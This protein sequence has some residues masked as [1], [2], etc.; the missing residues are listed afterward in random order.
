MTRQNW[1]ILGTGLVLAVMVTLVSGCGPKLYN[2]GTYKGISQ[3]DDHGYAVAEVTVKGD[4]ITAVKLTEFTQ[5]GVEKDFNTYP[6]AK[7]KEA[8][9]EMAKRF[10]GR[11]DANVDVVTGATNSSQKY[12]EAVQFALEKA[13][14]TPT[15]KSTYFEGTF[16]GRSKADDRGYGVAWVTIKGDKI[17]EVRLDDVTQEG[18]FKDWATYPYAKALEAKAEMEKRFVEKN[19]PQVDAYTGATSSSTK[20]IEAVNDAL[21][22]AKLK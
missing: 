10:V 12:K 2:D 20:W 9:V 7:S 22:N 1:F 14:K 6:Y 5:F 11:Q 4:K 15:M 21:Q 3:A 16:F 8:N 17:T 18:K 13:K 19:G